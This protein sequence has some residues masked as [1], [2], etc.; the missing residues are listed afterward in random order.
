MSGLQIFNAHPR[1][2]WGKYG[3][4]TD[5]AVLDIT[6]R[7]SSD[8]QALGVVRISNYELPTTG[9]L[10]VSR[11][12]LVIQSSEPS[13]AGD[14]SELPGPRHGSTLAFFLRMAT[15]I[16]QCFVFCD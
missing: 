16:Q 15:R 6:Q 3:A 2:Y 12:G 1:L 14:D 5:R 9:F 13:P 11:D 10:G 7:D 8:G 4:N